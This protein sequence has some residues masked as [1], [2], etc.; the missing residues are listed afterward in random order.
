MF[1]TPSQF[2]RAF[3]LS[4]AIVVSVSLLGGC[5][6]EYAD[7]A[8][9]VEQPV[10]DLYSRALVQ[11][12]NGQFLEASAG[13]DEVERQHPYSVWATR[14][15]IM[16][17]YSL[18]SNNSYEEAV[19]ALDRFIQLHPSNKDIPYA[20]YL[21]AL[22]FYERI[23]DVS[24]DQGMTREAM[25]TLRQLIG[26]FPNGKY[27]KDARIKLELTLD[28]LAGKQMDIGR[29][30][31]RRGQYLAAVNRFKIVIDDYQTTTHVPEALHRMAESY[32][33]LG[34][35]E[36][37]R[38]TA[39]VLGHNFP[40]SEWYMDSYALVEGGNARGENGQE[41]HWWKFW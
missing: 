38:K 33:A 19:A 35:R 32:T 28:H 6:Y 40:G 37:A 14:A 3:G 2:F 36:E 34:M 9:Y 7:E 39:A 21:R 8:E 10:E 16:G 18:Y 17:A 12:R 27:A 22:C 29:Y 1:Q 15:Q 24:R 25:K 23:S 13:F 5:A 31:M 20:Y 41:E 11:L 4:I 30:Y 26:R